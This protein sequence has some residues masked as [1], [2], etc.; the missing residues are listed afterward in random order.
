MRYRKETVHYQLATVR[1]S[2]TDPIQSLRKIVFN[3]MTSIPNHD[4]S[5]L[6]EYQSKGQ[7]EGKIQSRQ[8]ENIQGHCTQM[9]G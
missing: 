6:H 8:N 1:Q 3:I 4:L 5:K 9:Q 7:A 2:I